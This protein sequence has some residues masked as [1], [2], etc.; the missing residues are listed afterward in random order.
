MSLNNISNYLIFVKK[1]LD[2][3]R[4][5]ESIEMGEKKRYTSFQCIGMEKESEIGNT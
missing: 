5:L 1:D 3:K 2:I 4:E